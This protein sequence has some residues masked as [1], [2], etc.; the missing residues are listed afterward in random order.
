[1]S[2]PP[3]FS[4]F[5]PPPQTA[6]SFSSFRPRTSSQASASDKGKQREV[7]SD[8]GD[9]HGGGDDNRRRS[10]GRD[11]H[12]LDK[13]SSSRQHRHRSP[14][15]DRDDR[16]QGV[17][18]D[19]RN[20]GSTKSRRSHRSHRDEGKNH[21]RYKEETGHRDSHRHSHKDSHRDSHKGSHRDGQR[22]AHRDKERSRDPDLSAIRHHERT[23]ANRHRGVADTSCN[24][25]DRPGHCDE[26]RARVSSGRRKRSPSPEQPNV[27]RPRPRSPSPPQHPGVGSST[28]ESL[29]SDREL[30]HVDT[31][32]DSQAVMY[33]PDPARF[34]AF[35]R[36]GDGLVLGLAPT[37]RITGKSLRFK[38]GSSLEVTE[39]RQGPSRR[40]EE[41]A[42]SK[43]KVLRKPGRRFIPPK[44]TTEGQS[45][46]FVRVSREK[47]GFRE[48]GFSVLGNILTKMADERGGASGAAESSSEA[49]DGGGSSDDD[50]AMVED[51]YVSVKA[52]SRELHE[53]I[54]AEPTDV[55]AWLDLVDLQDRLTS[56]EA[57]DMGSRMPGA[58]KGDGAERQVSR[59]SRQQATLD[60]QFS[61]VGKAISAH[62]DNRR[63]LLLLLSR[64]QLAAHSGRWDSERLEK[65]WRKVLGDEAYTSSIDT[66]ARLWQEYLAW[67]CSDWASF[68]LARIGDAYSEAI[69]RFASLIPKHTEDPHALDQID[70]VLL[71]LFRGRL[72]VL[73]DAGMNEL[74]LAAVQSLL[75][76]N[77]C[78]AASATL[79]DAGDA[80][81]H[82]S[83]LQQI[84]RD[85]ED[86]WDSGKP[87]LMEEGARGWVG[88]LQHEEDVVCATPLE[89]LEGEP[90]LAGQHPV[91]RWLHAELRRSRLRRF[92]ARLTD[93]PDW[94]TEGME[95]DS[96][97]V[98]LFSDIE[99]ML[100]RL[101]GQRGRL[102]LLDVS[103]AFLG[104]PHGL[105]T[106]LSDSI[107]VGSE[108]E[109][110]STIH[111]G[112]YVYTETVSPRSTFWPS[113]LQEDATAATA[114]ATISARAFEVVDGEV[115]GRE[116][117]SNLSD[118][119][120][121]PVLCAPI[122]VE[123]L[124]CPVSGTG[125]QVA[126][127]LRS[128]DPA[129]LALA[130]RL[131]EQA[132]QH[133][134][135]TAISVLRLAISSTLNPKSAAKLA[136]K[137]LSE[138]RDNHVLWY[139]YARL[140]LCSG[141]TASARNI[142]ITA[143]NSSAGQ[144]Q[145][146]GAS[147]SYL[148]QMWCS[149]VEL[150]WK[151][152]EVR[153]AVATIGAAAK[154]GFSAPLPSANVR[155]MLESPE[156]PSGLEALRTRKAL[157]TL[158]AS[159]L[160]S[161]A[162]PAVPRG[163]LHQ[164]IFCLA[165]LDYLALPAGEGF[166]AAMAVLDQQL[167]L[168]QQHRSTSVQ[169]V[170]ERLSIKRVEFMRAHVVTGQSY[171]PIEVGR[172]L[173]RA[174]DV[175]PAN[176]VLWSHLATHEMRNKIDNRL[177]LALD[178]HI[179]KQEKMAV[180]RRLLQ[181]SDVSAM[182][183]PS[184]TTHWLF[185]VYVELNL[186]SDHFSEQAVR[187]LLQRAVDAPATR[188]SSTLWAVFLEF[189]TRL[190][191]LK[192]NSRRQ[193]KEQQSR[194]KSLLYRAVKACPGCKSIYLYAFRRPLRE[195]MDLD[196]ICTLYEVM[197]EKEIRLFVEL[198]DFLSEWRRSLPAVG[199]DQGADKDQAQMDVDSDGSGYD[200]P[201]DPNLPYKKRDDKYEQVG[202][203]GGG[204]NRRSAT[205][206]PRV[207]LYSLP[208]E[209]LYSIFVLAR[210]PSLAV[211]SRGLRETFRRAPTGV[212]V[213]YLLEMW[214]DNHLRNLAAWRDTRFRACLCAYRKAAD[215]AHTTPPPGFWN[216]PSIL[217]AGTLATCCASHVA[218]AA[219][220]DPISYTARFAVCTAEIV[221]RLEMRLVEI[222]GIQAV[223]QD[224]SRRLN[225]RVPPTV[226]TPAE[227]VEG[228]R[229]AAVT[230][231]ELP[232]RIFRTLK[233][234]HYG[235]YGGRRPG[236]T[237]DP[238]RGKKRNHAEMQCDAAAAPNDGSEEEADAYGY[239]PSLLCLLP[240][241]LPSG[242]RH[243]L[244]ALPTPTSLEL[245]LLLLSRYRADANSHSGFPL[246][247][248]VHSD[249]WTLVHVLIAYGADPS[250][251]DGL[252]VQIA[253][254]KGDMDGVRGLLE[255][256]EKVE[257]RWA[258]ALGNVA[259][260]VQ[261]VVRRRWCI[262]WYDVV[263]ASCSD[264]DASTLS[265]EQSNGKTA[266]RTTAA[267]TADAA[268]NEPTET[269]VKKRKL[270]DRFIPD[271]RHLREAIKAEAW[272]VVDYLINEKR[273]VPD[274]KALQLLDKKGM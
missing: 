92:A 154:C 216:R 149:L 241:F 70:Q 20:R 145:Q 207:G 164:V 109:E 1:M 47:P 226:A 200:D 265:C 27:R 123:S 193:L 214:H 142:F 9:K 260:R 172:A 152:G 186:H 253:V 245:L 77:L 254:R 120:A 266:P 222:D 48:E 101:A 29:V 174:V 188:A 72:D 12:D 94:Q 16:H 103:L 24:G 31:R 96:F 67:R 71:M 199:D 175:S 80:T 208:A 211:S 150:L 182:L 8:T 87:R 30:Y 49:S 116:R 112:A 44:A 213:E 99:P 113:T 270:A 55:G 198:D 39:Q 140:E 2:L 210:S 242:N 131:L 218:A 191:R 219:N 133:L 98:V 125:S 195:A 173:D 144:Q 146:T 143:L 118:P 274:I 127:C 88:Y 128:V 190:L 185:A 176:T 237:G 243:S 76:I 46:D 224:H 86:F 156:L 244:G 220:V 239:T 78:A 97:A 106:G 93:L 73:K 180:A 259:R 136:R 134:K 155:H 32:G 61:I 184:A 171:R 240:P 273:V 252:A 162:V 117:R 264:R 41:T 257:K 11:D 151:S 194:A 212:K 147:T 7:D 83:D 229:E 209:L 137:L 231:V 263:V 139:A 248:T 158:V 64:L 233:H 227:L 17:S 3:S 33:G 130:G 115:M 63:S 28:Q 271:S 5:R 52:R 10:Y 232:K 74:A 197:C 104:L 169:V 62:P 163:I 22:H 68:E 75:E 166:P 59:A 159:S 196:E 129:S 45:E 82:P 54:R 256:Q 192:A 84:L 161:A 23:Q 167:E 201:F 119:A 262:R 251:K 234:A 100:F 4:S 114:A 268:V 122:D 177:R 148:P 69:Q 141:K 53:R 258:L 272:N 21:E 170:A 217:T 168:L 18:T 107:D 25:G 236:S 255:R 132:S 50:V 56:V 238:A 246:A 89:L 102:D 202:G 37:F 105:L 36:S 110:A 187:R 189:E 19:H 108:D 34:P 111:D 215:D 35:E 247:M 206:S 79:S 225:R 13:G 261:D 6:P 51:P 269:S 42:R 183:T 57:A 267:T 181:P 157:Q 178:V 203:G 153:G 40:S 14:H 249:C 95:I 235:V 204:C 15:R 124:F 38:G 160:S 179:S 138:E 135:S 26:P 126:S 90:D 85:Y 66:A 81:A 58:R 221:I 223:L 250:K 205:T 230:H 121:C 65:E 91:D 43:W 165:L 228:S 60:V